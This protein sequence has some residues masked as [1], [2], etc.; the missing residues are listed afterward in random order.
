MSPATPSGG[1]IE[2]VLDLRGAI[3]PAACRARSE[4]YLQESG[5]PA[6]VLARSNCHW[7][8]KRFLKS[9]KR[10][11][12]SKILKLQF[13]YGLQNIVYCSFKI[14]HLLRAKISCGEPKPTKVT[15]LCDILPLVV[16]RARKE[17][18]KAMFPT[19][20]RWKF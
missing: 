10:K 17:Q 19:L 9:H 1:A 2:C 3:V 11:P 14:L 16:C 6:F 18:Q 5:L 4:R 13:Y 8:R 20:W 7:F 12:A 15:L